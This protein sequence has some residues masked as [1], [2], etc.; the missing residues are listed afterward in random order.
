MSSFLSKKKTKN[1]FWRKISTEP[2]GTQ[3][4]KRYAVDNFTWFVRDNYEDKT[5]NNVI[6][7]ILYI[8]KQDAENYEQILYEMLQDWINW[9]EKRGLGNY[10]IRVA[11]SNLRK[12]L[13]HFGIKT[14]E[15]DIR[16]NLRFGK[17]PRE[18]RH[19][20]SNEEYKSI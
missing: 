14:N 6:E 18:E 12:F 15:Q 7:E 1:S 17:I 19:P 9:N 16:E 8:K 3:R 20:L 2:I 11:F 13:F 10:T 4:Q 5:L